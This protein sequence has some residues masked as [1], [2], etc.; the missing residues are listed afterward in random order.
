MKY[1]FFLFIITFTASC[2]D[3]DY[4]P[5][6]KAQLRLEYQKP[7]YKR[8]DFTYFSTEKSNFA[9]AERVSDK[10][11]NLDYPAMNAKIYMTYNRIDNNLESLLRDAEKFTYEHTVKADEIITQDFINKKNRVFGTMNMVTGNAAS[12]IQ[13]H[14]TDSTHHFLDGSLYFYAQPNYDSI[15]PAVE[16]LQ[17]DIQHL[18]ETLQWK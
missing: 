4:M 5:K 6:P 8:I 3:A 11:I 15:M 13:F 1:I 17:K 12:Q 2:S 7:V 18:L 10:K 14:A 9:K 16:Y